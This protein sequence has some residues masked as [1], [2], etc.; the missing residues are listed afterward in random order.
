MSRCNFFLMSD[1]SDGNENEEVNEETGEVTQARDSAERSVTETPHEYKTLA[2]G[3]L[4]PR[5]RRLAFLA[6]QGKSNAEI[7]KEL[8][9]VDSRVSILLKNPHIAEEVAKLQE[10]IYEETIA[11]RLKS[12][13]EPALANIQMILTDRTNKVKVSEKMALSQWVI[14]K[15]DG[16]AAQKIEAGENLLA[17]LMDRLDAA[18]SRPVV[19]VNVSGVSRDQSIDVTPGQ[20]AQISPPKTEEDLLSDWVVDF[21]DTTQSV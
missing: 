11:A 19:Q 8:G 20:P 7:A 5:H 15:L 16:K 17:V 18:K 12:F 2:H 9:Y 21:E 1:V 4:S 6:A 13:A 10:R 3:Y 14:E